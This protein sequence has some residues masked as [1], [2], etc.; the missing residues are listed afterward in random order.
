MVKNQN[1]KTGMGTY[2]PKKSDRTT[3]PKKLEPLNLKNKINFEN[4][5]SNL[6]RIAR[7]IG[8]TN[9]C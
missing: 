9:F 5:K 6:V 7:E 1:H 4:L 3:K 2:K 8:I